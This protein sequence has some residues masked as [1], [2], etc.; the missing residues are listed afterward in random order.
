MRWLL[1]VSEVCAA[2]RQLAGDDRLWRKLCARLWATKAYIPQR[3]LEGTA[4]STPRERYVASI[5][6]STR[7][8]ITRDELCSLT[9]FFRFKRA[10]GSHWCGDDPYW[11]GSVARCVQFRP[12]GTIGRNG[13][14]LE[15]LRWA[16]V[17]HGVV[18]APPPHAAGEPGASGTAIAVESSQMGRFPT[19]VL[20][21]Q[22]DWGWCLN[23]L[24]VVYST[25]A[26]ER[27]RARKDGLADSQLDDLVLDFQHAQAEAYNQQGDSDDSDAES[28]DAESDSEEEDDDDDFDEDEEMD[29]DVGSSGDDEDD[30]RGGVLPLP[31]QQHVVRRHCQ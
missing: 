13:D 17:D 2:W 26:M 30:V 31:T 20:H 29:D 16:F 23:S 14:K 1:C 24:W 10:A 28:T 4:L 7:T 8:E 22:R 9:W 6:D 18:A 15:G 27:K 12:D 11:Q 19:E 3:F 21:R 5:A 25:T